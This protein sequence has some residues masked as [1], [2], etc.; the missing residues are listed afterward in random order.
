[1]PEIWLA[2]ESAPDQPAKASM[3]LGVCDDHREDTVLEDL[4]NDEG[5]ETICSTMSKAGKMVP[6]RALTE[7]RWI[8]V[9]EEWS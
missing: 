9:W 6:T 3:G 7:L 8:P 4:V 1:M 5:W 2:H